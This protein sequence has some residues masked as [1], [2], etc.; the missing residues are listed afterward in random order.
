MHGLVA[1][2][3]P[4]AVYDGPRGGSCIESCATTRFT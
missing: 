1:V 4:V 3:V 2:A